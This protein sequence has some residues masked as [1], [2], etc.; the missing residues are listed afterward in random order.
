MI[1]VSM[2]RATIIVVVVL[3]ASVGALPFQDCG[4]QYRLISVD[5]PTCPTAPCTLTLGDRVNISTN[6][7][8]DFKS[9]TVSLDAYYVISTIQIPVAVA[10]DPCSQSS[11]SVEQGETKQYGVSIDVENFLPPLDGDLVV[12]LFNENSRK[13]VCYI[14]TVR[15]R[16]KNNVCEDRNNVFPALMKRQ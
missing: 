12:Q 2:L 4:S 14:L 5:I 6:F 9:S 8:A 11:C 13:I 7:L 16:C 15:L 10:Y 3:C 1:I